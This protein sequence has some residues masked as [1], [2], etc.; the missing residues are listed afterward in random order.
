MGDDY[1]PS[2][3]TKE[4]EVLSAAPLPCVDGYIVASGC[5]SY[6]GLDS[7]T[8]SFAAKDTT[9]SQSPSRSMVSA[10]AGYGGTFH[11]EGIE[12]SPKL[13]SSQLSIGVFLGG[14]YSQEGLIYFGGI[15]EV[16]VE[17]HS[18]ERIR[19]QYNV[20][21]TLLSRAM[22]LTEAKNIGSSPG[23][24]NHSKKI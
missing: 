19:S 1:V 7:D 24:S 22:K 12:V 13:R 15:P 3:A 6:S 2:G 18:S 8:A 20:D 11:D 10:H 16:T 17:M 23:T 5:N 21:D 4:N 14:C 9:G